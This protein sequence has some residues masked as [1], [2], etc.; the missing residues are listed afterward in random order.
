MSPDRHARRACR[1]PTVPT[2]GL[3]T[4]DAKDPETA[5]PAD[6][7]LLPPEG[8]PNVLVVLVDDVGF[9][10]SSAFGGPFPTPTFGAPAAGG[11]ALHPVSHH[12]P[13]CADRQALLTGRNHHSVGWAASPRSRQL[14]PGNCSVLPNTK[15]ACGEDAET[16]RL[17]DRAVR[18]VPR[19]T[20]RGRVA[21]GPVRCV[22]HG[23]RRFQILLWLHRRRGQPVGPG[24]VRGH[25]AD[26]AA[27]HRRRGLSL[28]RRPGR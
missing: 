19:G 7:L 15:A 18:Q 24:A 12:S 9:G 6:H 4:Y 17:L 8:A 21:D 22:A 26:R 25:D 16:Q 10:S 27:R 2:F 28:H 14:A 20:G 13:V 5:Y 1:F 23:R 11:L 3:T